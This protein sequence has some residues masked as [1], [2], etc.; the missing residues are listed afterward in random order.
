[1]ETPETSFKESSEGHLL[2]KLP[3]QNQMMQK[4]PFYIWQRVLVVI[5]VVG[6]ECFLDANQLV[7]HLW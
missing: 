4:L 7:G 6:K 3:K 5:V 2:Q 1:V